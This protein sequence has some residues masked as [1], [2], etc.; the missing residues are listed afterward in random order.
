[1]IASGKA[2]VTVLTRSGIHNAASAKSIVEEAGGGV[3]DLFGKD[4]LRLLLSTTVLIA[5]SYGV[6]ALVAASNNN[7]ISYR[8]HLTTSA[9]SPQVFAS[10]CLSVCAC[11][12]RSQCSERASLAGAE[13]VRF[14]ANS[15][16]YIPLAKYG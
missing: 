4:L 16:R 10:V 15:A 6:G 11:C 9:T 12:C 1:M 8:T 13:A 7:I 2:A 14:C 3:T 5:L